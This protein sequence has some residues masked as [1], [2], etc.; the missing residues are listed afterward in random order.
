MP[1]LVLDFDGVICDSA[2][3]CFVSSWTAYHALYRGAPRSDPPAE[4]KASFR[5]L[6]PFIRSGE[7]FLLIQDLIENGISVHSQVE[8]DSAWS[9]QG[10]PP[11]NVFKDLFYRARTE[12]LEKDRRTWLSL[13]RI[14][15]HVLNALSGLP[16]E[17]P[18]YVLSTKK[19]QFVRET[20]DAGG[21][22]IPEAH[23]LYSHAEPKLVTVETLRKSLGFPDAI[24]VEDQIDAIRGNTNPRIRAF[25]ASW[26]Y[27][28]ESWLREEA[29][30]SVLDPDGFTELLAAFRDEV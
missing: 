28:Q 18:L 14:Y 1:L 6:R 7:D 16:P 27:V 15:P 3:E 17:A 25:L 24:L 20:L 13:N 12:L 21:I 11:R 23:I 29:G 2:E 26:G 22:T 9:R 8:F 19:P 4:A 30:I 10:V 5:S